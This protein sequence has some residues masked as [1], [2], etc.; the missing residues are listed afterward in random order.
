M[1][2]AARAKGSAPALFIDAELMKSLL[3]P[4]EQAASSISSE[5]LVSRPPVGE[6]ELLFLTVPTDDAAF[7]VHLLLDPDRFLAQLDEVKDRLHLGDALLLPASVSSEPA[8]SSAG[9]N[10]IGGASAAAVS[11]AAAAGFSPSG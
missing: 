2:P 6:R 9:V 11:A 3:A 10:S 8:S 4:L 5:C 7:V 1:S